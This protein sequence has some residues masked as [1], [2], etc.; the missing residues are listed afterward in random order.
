MKILVVNCGS[1]SLKYQLINMEDESVMAKGLVDRIGID[2][3]SLTHEPTGKSKMVF[4]ADIPDHSVGIKMVFDALTNPEYG[5][6]SDLKE[7]NG[8]GHRYVN[9]GVLF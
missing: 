8:V 3:S 4:E 2:N 6:I 9:G 1:S 5:V 7:I